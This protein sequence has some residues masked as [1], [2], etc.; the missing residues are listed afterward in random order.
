MMSLTARAASP[1]EGVVRGAIDSVKAL[2]AAEG[3]PEARRKLPDSSK[4]LE[5]RL[6]QDRGRA[7]RSANVAYC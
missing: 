1:G 2:P 7:L 5:K 3:E 4:E 6:A